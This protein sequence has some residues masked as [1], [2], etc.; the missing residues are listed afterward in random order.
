MASL[1]TERLRLVFEG[2]PDILTGIEKA[3]GMPPLWT[4]QLP[5]YR[6]HHRYCHREI[7]IANEHCSPDTP[8][9]V[10]LFNNIASFVQERLAGDSSQDGPAAKRRRVDVGNANGRANGTSSGGASSSGEAASAAATAEPVLLEV[11][12]ISV[13]I[14]QRKKFDLCMTKN[15]LY[16]RVSGA[17]AP[18]QGI[19]YAWKDIGAC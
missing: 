16:A 12:D 5:Q 17:S 14:P 13:S 19:V 9:R 11:K 15:Y 2:R 18:A 1:D 8:E 10:A 7:H 6:P 4:E 3:A